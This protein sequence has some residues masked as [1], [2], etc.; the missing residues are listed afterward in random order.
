ME[1][2]VLIVLWIITIIACITICI[3]YKETKQLQDIHLEQQKQ[4]RYDLE[5]KIASLINDIAFKE[6]ILSKTNDLIVA[7]QQRIDEIDD[8]YQNEKQYIQDIEKLAAQRKSQLQQE[9]D[10]QLQY[11]KDK[12]AAY[13]ESINIEKIKTQNEL[14]SLKNTRKAVVEAWRSEE[15][16]SANLKFYRLDI[17]KADINDIKLLNNIKLNFSNPRVISKLI[18][19]TYFQPLAKK[20]FVLI[21]GANKITGIYKITNTIDHRVYIGQAVDVYKRWCDHCKCGCGIDCPSNNKLYIAMNENGL[22]NFTF[23]L[24]EECTR[25]ELNKKEAFYIDLYQSVDFGYNSQIGNK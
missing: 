16:K 13:Q 19:Q 4:Q 8:Q 10:E 15:L 14:E 12:M 1:I 25:E 21:L 22:E 17:S 23:E 20:K 2:N 7:A 18:W 9:Y 3:K 11:Q 5:H 6:N 24:L